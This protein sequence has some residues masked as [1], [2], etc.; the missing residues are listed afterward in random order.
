MQAIMRSNLVCDVSHCVLKAQ[1]YLVK[2]PNKNTTILVQSM[3]FWENN[4][5]KVETVTMLLCTRDYFPITAAHGHDLFFACKKCLLGVQWDWNSIMSTST[6][7][8]QKFHNTE[9]HDTDLMWK[10]R[11]PVQ[12]FPNYY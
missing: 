8:T 2:K 4:H 1:G 12:F 9:R 7:K 10:K 3:L 6:V 11:L 5:P